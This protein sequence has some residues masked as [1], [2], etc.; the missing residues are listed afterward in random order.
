[1]SDLIVTYEGLASP[2]R[3]CAEPPPQPNKPGDKVNDACFFTLPLVEADKPVEKP[4]L[5]RFDRRGDN[6]TLS[7]QNSPDNLAW[8]GR[9]QNLPR[10]TEIVRMAGLMTRTSESMEDFTN[11]LRFVISQYVI[12]GVV[13]FPNSGLVRSVREG[14]DSQMDLA[15]LLL[16]SFTISTPEAVAKTLGS[17][18]VA[19]GTLNLEMRERIEWVH[20]I[21]DLAPHYRSFTNHFVSEAEVARM[22]ELPAARQLN[23]RD[24]LTYCRKVVIQKW[25]GQSLQFDKDLQDAFFAFQGLNPN[26][27]IPKLVNNFCGLVEKGLKG[28]RGPKGGESSYVN[29]CREGLLLHDLPAEASIPESLRRGMLSKEGL[30]LLQGH[31]ARESEKAKMSIDWLNQRGRVE[32]VLRPILKNIKIQ[33]NPPNGDPSLSLEASQLD[34]ELTLMIDAHPTQRREY[35]L[36]SLG[37][38]NRL[39]GDAA[40][41]GAVRVFYKGGYRQIPWNLDAE[42]RE[43][44]RHSMR[45]IEKRLDVSQRRSDV[46]LPVV[47]GMTCVLG[48]VGLGL[49]EGLAE[50]KNRPDLHLGI[51]TTSAGLLGAGCSSLAAHFILPKL[52]NVRNRYM[53]EGITAAGGLVLGTGFY[54]LGSLKGSGP[55]LSSAKYPVDPYGP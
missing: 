1:M 13:R 5:L 47:E 55:D 34:L 40:Q 2:P 45:G 12:S 35:I 52:A 19:K 49:S 11:K 33:F 27:P 16:G 3:A 15:N 36:A 32:E 8:A 7:P 31:I 44:L 50:V 6:F 29:D 28:L 22:E 23:Y 4:R 24:I 39:F 20:S 43:R 26:Q 14:G 42:N 10:I 9:H 51:G 25:M 30:T 18:M 38:L 53:W 48:A 54:L 21:L 41:P 37:L 46:W 17:L